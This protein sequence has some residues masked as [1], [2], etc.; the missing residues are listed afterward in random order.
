MTLAPYRSARDRPRWHT[1]STCRTTG[2]SAGG[3]TGG[4]AGGGPDG[5]A[6]VTP[7]D[8]TPEDPAR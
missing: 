1:C 6:P 3:R 8:G 4:S 7:E 5:N 2:E